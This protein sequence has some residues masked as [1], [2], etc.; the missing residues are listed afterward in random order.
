[1]AT[2]NPTTGSDFLTGSPVSDSIPALENN[3]TIFGME[4]ED[5]LNG[6]EDLDLINGN[7]NNDLVIGD[8]GKDTLR[9]G[10]NND[11]LLANEGNDIIYGD[12]GNDTGY[13]GQG[14]DQLFGGQGP[15]A[16]YGG[17]GNDV[18]FGEQ[19]ND[20]VLGLGGDDLAFGNEDA[21]IV[22]GNEGNDTV[23]GGQNN[24]IVRGGQNNDVIFGD[25]NND[26]IYGDLGDDTGY[27]GEGDDYL[28]GGQGPEADFGGNG[29]DVLHGEQG[30]DYVLGLD[31]NDL[32]YGNEDSDFV[33]GN[34]GNDIV[35][36]GEGRDTLRGGRDNDRVFG[37]ED[38]DVLW[39]DLG[40]DSLSG[41]SGDDVFVIG[42][43]NDVSGFLTTG[44][45]TIADADYITDFGDGLD[46]IALTGG[47]NF[48]DL[49]ILE[50][51]GENAGNILIQDKIT[52]EYLVNLK[53]VD[54]D[55]ITKANFTYSPIRIDNYLS[56]TNEDI[57]VREDGTSAVA[58]TIS[59]TDGIDEAV[60]ATLFAT[61][62]TA[63]SPDDYYNSTPIAINF[64]AGE[65]LKTVNIP[66]V[67][68]SIAEGD[69]TFNLALGFPA[70]GATVAPPKTA[71]VT[72]QDGTSSSPTSSPTNAGTLEFTSPTFAV[73][74]NG[75]PIASVTVTRTGGSQGAVSAKLLLNGGTALGGTSPSSGADYNNNFIAV[76]WADGDTVPKVVNIPIFNDTVIEG[77]ETVNVSLCDSTGGATIGTLNS[78][79][80]TITDD[81]GLSHTALNPEIQILDGSTNIVDGTTQ[82]I[83]LGTAT[84]GAKLT[85]TFTIQN[86]ST[87]DTLNLTQWTLPD[88]FCLVGTI[89]G[90]VAPKSSA[91]FTVE[92]ATS[93][94]G[95]PE[96]IIAI[97]SN[98]KDESTFNFAV[99][100]TVED[101]SSNTS[102]SE[103][104]ILD[105]S[106]D[107][108]D[109]STEA[110]D[111]GTANVGATLTKTFSIKNTSSSDN[112]IL[113]NWSLP[114]GFSLQGSIPTNLAPNSASQF[115]LKVDTAT[116]GNLAGNLAIANNDSDENPFNFA[117]A[118]TVED[119]SSNTSGSEI[120][121]LDGST[122]IVD[123]STEAI[124]FG[125]TTVGQTLT[126]TFTIKN[127]GPN[128]TLNLSNWSL[129]DGFSL[130]GITPGIVAPGSQATFTINVDTAKAEN[131]E[132]S[133]SIDTN[134]SNENP[135][136]FDLT[137]TVNSSSSEVQILGSD[138]SD[139]IQGNDG[140][141]DRISP[142]GGADFLTWTFVPPM[143]VTDIIT[144]FSPEE[145]IVQFAKANYGNIS[146]ID[147]VSVSSLGHE[148]DDISAS[149]LV[150]FDSTIDFTDVAEVD[151]KLS[152]QNGTSQTAL[153]FLYSSGGNRYLG[154]DPDASGPGNAVS[155]TQFDVS[156]MPSNVMMF[157]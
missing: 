20:I 110:I 84:V 40:A 105:G 62:G 146:E 16:D 54:I 59:R 83:D 12:L 60:S 17:N 14:Q 98:D 75:T 27:G 135:F 90:T 15:E 153:F 150:V 78:A 112:L 44:G 152:E 4:G 9:G 136:N 143:G 67:N 93:K 137:A 50:G 22:N 96:G 21:D 77:N 52:K 18:L 100:A 26:T 91:Y 142:G 46:L 117:V 156:P 25:K 140:G 64:A 24:D 87:T 125:T 74:E 155:I 28:F 63:K 124:D 151:L 55:S 99:E 85:K 36:G 39:G 92:V 7:E 94:A 145:D 51:S 10:Q 119:S 109:G 139:T 76:N 48:E 31:G 103:I 86:T 58:V 8:I 129:S 116:S 2:L 6:N 95:N 122:N 33:D 97:N 29:S 120:Q 73:D 80:L 5:I 126:K 141:V 148:G 108:V 72:I 3:D 115:I 68:D 13:G 127:I 69:E 19:D 45:P 149:T 138:G 101:S 130:V 30:K 35:Y 114:N 57:R 147:P 104:Q 128:D 107:I 42:R 23:R 65:T 118:A 41:G 38:N 88:N 131:L 70:N 89:P 81:E 134:D 32:L 66:I 49:N 144:G 132:G 37:D 1:M 154:Y 47:L 82:A 61:D 123:G 133:I 102:G 53:G 157:N 43:R 11:S 56:F 34:E 79:V 113:S 111:F 106:A 71:T 121:I